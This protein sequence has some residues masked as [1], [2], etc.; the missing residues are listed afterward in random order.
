LLIILVAIIG[1]YGVIY[2][3]VTN[4]LM[5]SDLDT[6]KSELS[7]VQVPVNNDSSIK[8]ME[9]VAA[10]TESGSS[11]EYVTEEFMGYL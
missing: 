11:L 1:T 2:V 10:Y 6:F 9:N 7:T 4:V 8:E 5:P 3:A